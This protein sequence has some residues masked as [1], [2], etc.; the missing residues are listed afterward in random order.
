[1]GAVFCLSGCDVGGDAEGSAPISISIDQSGEL[2]VGVCEPFS[3]TGV[4]AEYRAPQGSWV[5]FWSYEGMMEMSPGSVYDSVV[6]S[7]SLEGQSNNPAFEAGGDIT[8]YIMSDP[9]SRGS[10]A[11]F[12]IEDPDDTRWILDDGTVSSGPCD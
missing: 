7:R 10:I 1:M 11:I 12:P 6:L 4:T 8:V 2:L 9:S 5:R 3:I